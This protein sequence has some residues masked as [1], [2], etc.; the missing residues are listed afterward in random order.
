LR[1]LIAIHFERRSGGL[2]SGLFYL[3][4]EIG[5]ATVISREHARKGTIDLLRN[6]RCKTLR[7]HIGSL[8]NPSDPSNSL[9]MLHH[10]CSHT[11]VRLAL[12]DIYG[13]MGHLTNYCVKY[14]TRV[15]S[16]SSIQGCRCRWEM[17]GE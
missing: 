13:E 7:K 3:Y 10:I 5:L 16:C 8:C 1:I 2:H 6:T 14:C 11:E 12:E 9:R 15:I 4:T 17:L